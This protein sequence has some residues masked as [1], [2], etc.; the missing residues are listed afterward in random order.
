M[1]LRA[2]TVFLILLLIA[3]CGPNL[4]S[5]SDAEDFVVGT[6]QSKNMS[7]EKKIFLE[8]R[9]DGNYVYKESE[10]KKPPVFPTYQ[11]TW[12]IDE[13]QERSSGKKFYYVFFNN[14]VN[15]KGQRVGAR[16]TKK[17]ELD[18]GLLMESSAI[19]DIKTGY[20]LERKEFGLFDE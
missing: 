13:G 15:N 16:I 4:K 10:E 17:G 7:R 20:L 1:W 2:G 12:F 3:G 18:V 11:G 8:I 9:G 14:A 5:T 6:W 19:P